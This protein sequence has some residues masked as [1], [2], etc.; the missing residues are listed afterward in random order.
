MT[1][2]RSPVPVFSIP[3]TSLPTVFSVSSPLWTR[4]FTHTKMVQFFFRMTGRNHRGKDLERRNVSTTNELHRKKMVFV[5]R[6]KIGLT[7]VI[8]WY[9]PHLSYFKVPSSLYFD[10]E[11]FLLNRSCIILSMLKH[12]LYILPNVVTYQGLPFV[13]LS[14]T[15]FY[16]HVTYMTCMYHVFFEN[17]RIVKDPRTCYV[18]ILLHVVFIWVLKVT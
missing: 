5:R 13:F 12:P 15:E 10:L 14:N 17:S 4:L 3:T 7:T 9:G 8:L 1:T 6:Y 2:R 18:Q 16:V 11:T